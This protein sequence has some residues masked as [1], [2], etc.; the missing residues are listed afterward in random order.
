MKRCKVE[1]SSNPSDKTP[2]W[3]VTDNNP[4]PTLIRNKE[5]VSPSPSTTASMDGPPSVETT[6]TSIKGGKK[7]RRGKKVTAKKATP[8]TFTA[9]EQEMIEWACNGF[10]P[11]GPQGLWPSPD[12]QEQIHVV[13]FEDGYDQESPESNSNGQDSEYQ[14]R[15]KSKVM[16]VHVKKRGGLVGVLLE[17]LC[18]GVGDSFPSSFPFSFTKLFF[19]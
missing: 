6:P 7:K 8:I 12:D 16:L 15:K 14:P 2:R 9:Y 17:S 5:E 11:S 10:F 4:M 19:L 3:A 13:P 18:V 1:L